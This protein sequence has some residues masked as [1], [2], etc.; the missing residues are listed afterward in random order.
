[1]AFP[2]KANIIIQTPIFNTG[3]YAHK[4]CWRRKRAERSARLLR[5]WH[6]A[7]RQGTACVMIVRTTPAFIQCWRNTREQQTKPHKLSKESIGHDRCRKSTERTLTGSMK[8]NTPLAALCNMQSLRKLDTSR[9]TLAGEHGSHSVKPTVLIEIAGC[10][11]QCVR[12]V[13]MYIQ[14]LCH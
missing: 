12:V 1:M 13:Y 8:T 2:C 14:A 9:K 7:S 4:H 10:H 11:T 3:S 5:H 6:K